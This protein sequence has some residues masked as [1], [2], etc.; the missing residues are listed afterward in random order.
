MRLHARKLGS[1]LAF[2]PGG[3]VLWGRKVLVWCLNSARRKTE[4]AKDTIS[5]Q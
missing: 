2:L 1:A 3:V 4:V 5:D